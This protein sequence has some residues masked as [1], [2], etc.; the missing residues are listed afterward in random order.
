LERE[1]GENKR[2]IMSRKTIYKD[3]D[4]RYTDA[5]PE[6]DEAFARSVRIPNFLPPSEEFV[7]KNSA[8]SDDDEVFEYAG[9]TQFVSYKAAN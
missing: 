5:P 6:V 9:K 4:A 3:N 1:Y 2:N 8:M 7:F